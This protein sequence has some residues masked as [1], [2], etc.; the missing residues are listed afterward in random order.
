MSGDDSRR[1]VEDTAVDVSA[2]L[3]MAQSQLVAYAQD[4]RTICERE[5]KKSERIAHI[6]L[7][8]LK[9]LLKVLAW[10]DRETA[11]HN[12]RL[13][14]YSLAIATRMGIKPREAELIA[15]AAPMHDI[16]KIGI[17][18]AIL[19][20]QGPLD[21]D[22]WAIMKTHPSLGAGLLDAEV[23]PILRT[24]RDI[25][26]CH[27]ERWDGSGY[28]RGLSA[29]QIPTSARIVAIADVYDALRSRRSYKEGFDHRCACEIISSGDAR[30]RPNHFD[31]AVM[32]A[33]HDVHGEF[34]TIFG[35]LPDEAESGIEPA[36]LL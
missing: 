23:S 35:E 25:A 30:T 6:H 10:K 7:D 21:D 19:Q 20:K 36:G 34:E 28:P 8:V 16:G 22:E 32:S 11:A 17:P 15:A 27:H 24:A 12:T 1:A 33:F 3:A 9:R 5:R 26:L 14:R 4:L 13:G 18:D 2:D 29:G 31:P